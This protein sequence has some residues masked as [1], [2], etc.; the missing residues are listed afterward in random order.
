MNV[1]YPD[2]KTPIE[3]IYW[4]PGAAPNGTYNV[5]VKYFKQHQNIEANPYLITVKYG[6]KTDEYTGTINNVKE[7]VHVCT[8]TL[9]SASNVQNPPN[10]NPNNPNTPP[11]DDLRRQ[12]EQERDRLQ[13]ELERVNEELRKL[14]NSL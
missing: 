3:N 11:T 9:G 2:S 10:A 4:P 12:L 5:Y 14:R 6:E 8:F 1:E 7:T 13:K